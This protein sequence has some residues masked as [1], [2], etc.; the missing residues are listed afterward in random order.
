[1]EKAKSIYLGGDIISAIDCDYESS[2]NLGLKCP[3]C[4]EAVYF[5]EGTIRNQTLRNGKKKEQIIHPLFAHYPNSDDLV[6]CDNRALTKEG[7]EILNK[8]II[9]SKNQRLKLYNDHLWNIIIN[10]LNLNE[11]DVTRLYRQKTN[12]I[13]LLENLFDDFH[14]YWKI[15]INFLKID[16]EFNRYIEKV[17]QKNFNKNLIEYFKIYSKKY[18]LRVCGEVIHYLSSYTSKVVFSKLVKLCLVIRDKEQYKYLNHVT[19]LS[20]KINKEEIYFLILSII[21]T[22]KWTEIIHER[23]NQIKEYPIHTSAQENE[24]KFKTLNLSNTQSFNLSQQS[25][26]KNASESTK[27]KDTISVKK[28]KYRINWKTD[29]NIPYTDP[30]IYK[31]EI[32][33]N[34]KEYIFKL[35]IHKKL[36]SLEYPSG[37]HYCD[38]LTINDD[39]SYIELQNTSI[40]YINL[41]SDF[42]HSQ[43]RLLS[44]LFLS[45][46]P[47]IDGRIDA[48]PYLDRRSK[49][50][51]DLAVWLK[52][53]HPEFLGYKKIVGRLDGSTNFSVKYDKKNRFELARQLRRL[54]NHI[55]RNDPQDEELLE[56]IPILWDI[57]N[58]LALEDGYNLNRLVTNLGY[59]NDEFSEKVKPI[60]NL[61]PYWLSI[62]DD[63]YL[64]KK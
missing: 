14:D 63:R 39:G 21:F 23:F 9:E 20:E 43:R 16:E 37:I 33:I 22:T 26:I 61:I 8:L 10:G 18:H 54:L 36:C 58:Y 47:E 49:L 35:D 29:K 46:N 13:A 55:L 48:T 25:K 1:M 15:E 12:D 56:I 38:L 42:L 34:D 53:K 57:G 32:T 17:F 45:V 59:D 31:R 6:I 41:L 24:N 28:T 44:S 64:P 27:R 7:T 30:Y 50:G 2:R 19:W 62:L 51:E 5:R 3:F 60:R 40:E 4:D 52:M 11:K